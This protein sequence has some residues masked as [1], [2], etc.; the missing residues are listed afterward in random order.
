MEGV[1][2]DGVLKYGLLTDSA[3]ADARSRDYTCNI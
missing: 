1:L 3:L 2:T